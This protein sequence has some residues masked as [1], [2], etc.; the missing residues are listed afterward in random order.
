MIKTIILVRRII[1]IS[2]TAICSIGL[3]SQTNPGDMMFVGFNADGNDGFAVVTL[4]EIPAN[5]TYYFSDNEW[6]GQPIGSGGDFNNYNEGELTWSTGATPISAGTVITFDETRSAANTNY[7]SSH[8]SITGTIDV[9]SANEVIYCYIG[10]DPMTVTGF[11]T[12]IA[13]LNFA[14]IRGTLNNT[15]LVRGVTATAVPGQEDLMVYDGDTECSGTTPECAALIADEDNWSAQDG[16]GDQSSDGTYP[17][18]PNDVPA[19]FFGSALPIELESFDVEIFGENL[20]MVSW[21]TLTETENDYFTIERSLDGRNWIIL[22]NIQGAGNSSNRLSYAF[23]DRNPYAG[24]S[25]YRLKQ[26][27]FNGAYSY[28]DIETVTIKVPNS[29]VVYPNPA[30]SQITILSKYLNDQEVKFYNSLGHEVN[31]VINETSDTK[32]SFQTEELLPGIYFV[33]VGEH[34]Q[35]STFIKQ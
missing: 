26:T 9:N 4:V 21:I 31:V 7:G 22:S 33:R 14:I 8:G 15:G 3:F 24:T 12:A 23:E 1:L 29:L 19:F 20:V 2:V 6:N 16:G 30:T 11:I 18:F 35:Y 32:K 28:F 10:T 27:D 25:Y 5:S 34:N 17:D 13:N